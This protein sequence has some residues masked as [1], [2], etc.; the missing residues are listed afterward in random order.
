MK[1]DNH[2]STNYLKFVQAHDKEWNTW[3]E[4]QQ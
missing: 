3:E 4:N 1:R 2:G